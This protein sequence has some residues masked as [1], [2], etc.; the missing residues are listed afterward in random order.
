M[1]AAVRVKVTASQPAGTPGQVVA[2]S[3]AASAARNR[4]PKPG[5]CPPPRAAARRAAAQISQP[6]ATSVHSAPTASQ[7]ARS[8]PPR[9]P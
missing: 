7:G 3:A 1:S 6:A 9:G 4:L 8:W 2:V 5:T